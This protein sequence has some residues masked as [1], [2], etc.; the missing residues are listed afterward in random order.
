MGKEI[1]SSRLGSLRTTARHS[2]RALL[3][4]PHV[5]GPHTV[6][7]GGDEDAIRDALLDLLPPSD[8]P[9]LQLTTLRRRI[10]YANGCE[11]LWYLRADLLAVLALHAGE[12]QARQ[13]LAAIDHLFPQSLRRR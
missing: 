5:D 13:Q 11:A 6:F 4:R 12:A 3:G 7:Q 2:L 9:T 1:R 10:R 8:A